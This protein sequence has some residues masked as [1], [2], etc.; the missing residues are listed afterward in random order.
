M[1]NSVYEQFATVHEDSASLFDARLNEKVRELR[2]FKPKVVYSDHIPFY[3]HVTYCVNE[4]TPETVA[5][6]SEVNGVSF[7]CAQCPY[8]RPALTQDGEVDKRCKWGD[9]EHAEFGR[10]YKTTAA[11]DKLYELIREGDVKLCFRD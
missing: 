7:V 2:A 5:E 6:A 9:C 1:R 11:C 4:Q 8:F 3:A 10:T